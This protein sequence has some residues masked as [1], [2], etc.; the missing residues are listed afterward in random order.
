MKSPHY[1]DNLARILEFTSGKHI[2]T[3]SQVAKYTSQNPKTCVKRYPFSG[4]EITAEVLAGSMCPKLK[5]Q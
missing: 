5:G 4:T 3:V 1:R 2:L